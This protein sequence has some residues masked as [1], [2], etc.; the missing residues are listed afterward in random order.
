M[1]NE[2]T[3]KL[4]F[5]IE[6]VL[7]IISICIYE[8]FS[9]DKLLI[10]SQINFGVVLAICVCISCSYLL[11]QF[12]ENDVWENLLIG[13]NFANLTIFVDLI[14]SIDIVLIVLV[15]V[16]LLLDRKRKCEYFISVFYLVFYET[17]GILRVIC[18][19]D[20]KI[21]YIVA[22][23]IFI[24]VLMSLGKKAKIAGKCKKVDGISIFIIIWIIVICVSNVIINK[25]Y[26][27]ENDKVEDFISISD[28]ESVIELNEMVEADGYLIATS[29]ISDESYFSFNISKL[30]LSKKI[31][32]FNVIIGE[33]QPKAMNLIV[34]IDGKED[35]VLTITN[36]NNNYRIN[37]TSNNLENIKFKVNIPVD[38][39]KIKIIGITF[40]DEKEDLKA[41]NWFC[42]WRIIMLII[43]LTIYYLFKYESLKDKFT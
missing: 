28:L 11:T 5:I 32:N 3:K 23:M 15:V 37:N 22:F 29:D 12:I 33:Q 14:F 24:F 17:Y 26:I 31:E 9:I 4:L 35:G 27:L 1:V 38:K 19:E 30:N 8:Y 20:T 39:T 6:I 43:I 36:G 21:L 16:Y 40:N 25:N 7:T 13:I 10:N 41:I 2:R 42:I 18:Y 34:E